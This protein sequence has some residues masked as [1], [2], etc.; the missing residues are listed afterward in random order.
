M[1]MFKAFV[2]ANRGWKANCHFFYQN[3]KTKLCKPCTSFTSNLHS[4]CGMVWYR[5]LRVKKKKADLMFWSERRK[6]FYTCV[7]ADEWRYREGVFNWMVSWRYDGAKSYTDLKEGKLGKSLLFRK[8]V[9]GCLFVGWLLNVP[10]TGEFISGTDPLICCHTE[11]EVADQTFHL[12]HSQ[13]TDTGLTSPSTD[14]I[15]PGAWQG[16]HWYDSSPEKSWLKQDLNPGSSALE[17]D[18][19]TT[20][21][22]SEGRRG[23][24]L[25][26]HNKNKRSSITDFSGLWKRCLGQ[27]A[28]RA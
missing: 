21:S 7:S 27:A 2:I 22:A 18:A 24:G 19:L 12:T 13:Y 17:A 14:P 4:S 9:K 11:I 28:K 8:P 16:N 1:R 5:T 23:E 20:R 10:A 3:V 26:G 6:F 25:H 15:T